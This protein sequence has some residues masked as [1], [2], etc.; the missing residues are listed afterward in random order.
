MR[1]KNRPLVFY[2]ERLSCNGK[3]IPLCTSPLRD[4]KAGY[5]GKIIEIN[6]N[7]YRLDLD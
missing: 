3:R 5:Y 6:V 4:R 7:P 1:K 2:K